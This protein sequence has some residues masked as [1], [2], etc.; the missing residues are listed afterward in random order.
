MLGDYFYIINTLG[1]YMWWVQPKGF[2]ATLGTQGT[3]DDRSG[4]GG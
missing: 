2:S 1:P 3:S 4:L